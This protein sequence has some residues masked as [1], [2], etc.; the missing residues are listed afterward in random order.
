MNVSNKTLAVL[1]IAAIVVS[2]GGTLLSGGQKTGY[3]T[4]AGTVNYSVSDNLVVNFTTINIDFGTGFVVESAGPC[5]IASDAAPDAG[6]GGS[7][8]S[9][10]GGLVFENIGNTAC[11][12]NMS[13]NDTD[14]NFIGS[15]SD[16][17]VKVTDGGA[18]C[19]GETPTA[20]TAVNDTDVD[21]T[22]CSSLAITGG[23]SM[24]LD[25]QLSISE[26]DG[27]SGTAGG[28]TINIEANDAI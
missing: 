10:P 25:F 26:A 24:T 23:N 6:C 27:T 11:S 18:Y 14:T 4:T 17:K 7:F 2:L 19:T 3:A 9:S 15:T 21:N 8:E 22:I 13:V 5:I 28:L 20:Y 12:V 16:V 1:L